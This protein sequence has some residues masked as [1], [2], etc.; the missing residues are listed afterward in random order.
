VPAG[1][2]LGLAQGPALDRDEGGAEAL[3]AAVVL[4]AGGLVDGPLAAQGGLLWHQAHAAGLHRAVATAFAHGAVD[5]QPLG[6]VGELAP[7]AAA[8]LLGGAGL[9]VDQHGGAGLLP[10]AGLHGDQ[11]VPVVDLDPGG[12]APPLDQQLGAVGHHHALPGALRQHLAGDIA[13]GEVAFHRLAPGHGHGVV[14]EDLVGDVLAGRHG[15]ADGHEAGVVVGA[16]PHVLEDV[17]KAREVAQADP[18]GAL[19]PHVGVGQHVVV[20]V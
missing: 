4:V 19:A 8:A 1:G 3:H 7:L 14:E 13:H 16:I 2:L 11:L 5:E 18:L 6:G 9:F 17:P 12:E 20:V 10:Q 15:T